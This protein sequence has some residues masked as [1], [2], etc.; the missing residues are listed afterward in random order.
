MMDKDLKYNI[1]KKWLYSLFELAHIEFQRRLWIN[2]EYE[3][4]IGNY[5]ESIC[6]YFNDL[7]L[8]DGYD[9]MLSQKIITKSEFDIVEDFHNKL[10]KYADSPEKKNLSDR[11]KLID[12]EWINL[13]RIAKENWE[14]IKLDIND[15]AELK[16]MYELENKYIRN[17]NAT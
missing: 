17:K 8:E 11:K 13:T 3:D 14:R 9:E 15:Y 12:P 5:D 4:M 1:R 6:Q 10:E 2:V 16:F 7:D